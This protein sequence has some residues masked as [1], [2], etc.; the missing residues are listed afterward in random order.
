MSRLE[1]LAATADSVL[2]AIIEMPRLLFRRLFPRCSLCGR[3]IKHDQLT[4]TYRAA[5]PG[6]PV[7]VHRFCSPTVRRFAGFAD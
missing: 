5:W 1:S 2:F 6:G 4:A 7:R 3:R